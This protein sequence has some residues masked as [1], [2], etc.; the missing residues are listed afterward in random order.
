MTILA[1]APKL[2]REPI[3]RFERFERFEQIGQ[4]EQIEPINASF[5]DLASRG[6]SETAEELAHDAR[7]FLSAIEVYCELLAAPG[8]LSPRFRHYAEDLHRIGRTGARLVDRLAARR[9]PLARSRETAPEGGPEASPA[10]HPFP[11]SHPFP[12]IEDLADELLALEAPLRALAGPEARLEI[13]CAPCAGQLGLNSEALMRVLFNL[14]A[15]AVEAMASQSASG[16][17]KLIRISAG[18]GAGAGFLDGRSESPGRPRASRPAPT[19][20]LSVRDNGPGISPGDLPRVFDPGF[21][22][23]GRAGGEGGEA[24]SPSN[25][26]G[27]WRD[28]GRPSGRG[29][30]IVR[31]LVESAGGTVRA[32]S[33]F[34]FGARFDIE[35]PC[36]IAA[37]PPGGI[38]QSGRIGT[39]R[40]PSAAGNSRIFSTDEE[41]GV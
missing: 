26:R 38:R 8:V 23:R 11:A 13:Q 18:P 6:G 36:A 4:I 30:A 19:V 2:S 1:P 10:G 20:V 14:V 31:R 33:S 5:P 34:G 17:R 15:N 24:D 22:T 25:G 37:A 21:T 35:L 16:R 39:A 27:P 7:N 3:E 32:V 29:L 12:P 28:G 9:A 41:S 40:N